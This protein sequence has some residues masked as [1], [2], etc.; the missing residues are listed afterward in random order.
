MLENGLNYVTELSGVAHLKWKESFVNVSERDYSAL[1]FRI[2]GKASIRVGDAVYNADSNDILYLPQKTAYT[3]EY[4]D[5][6]ILVIHFKTN[7]DDTSP[8][9][10]R[11]E[12]PEHIYRV[13]LKAYFLWD[14]KEPGYQA[15]ILS[16]LYG[17][18]A[19]ISKTKSVN[20]LRHEHL[21]VISFMHSNFRDGSL[22]V[23]KICKEAGI[24]ETAFR[25]FMKQYCG[26]TPIEYLTELRLEH[27]RNLIACGVTIKQAAFESG[28]NDPKYFSR[29]VKKHY[30]CMAR[31]LKSFGK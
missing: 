31:N 21:S 9:V 13:F 22:S 29:T 6:E 3:A 25:K 18:L 30:G 4:S 26:K 8:E 1:A 14:K 23:P 24:S 27:A 15:E 17:I 10:H 7:R 16:L 12:D 11:T 20:N 5:T 28:F 19:E 2:K